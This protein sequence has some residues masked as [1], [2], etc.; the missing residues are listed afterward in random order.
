MSL[1]IPTFALSIVADIPP[2]PPPGLHALENG[3]HSPIFWVISTV[4]LAGLW[5]LLRRR[6]KPPARSSDAKPP[7]KT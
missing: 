1:M 6:G 5:F 3:A 7:E 2:P 4:A